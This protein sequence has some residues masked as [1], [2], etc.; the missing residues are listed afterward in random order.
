[1]EEVAFDSK[2]G[3][4]VLY[5]GS[6][7]ND[8]NWSEPTSTSEW[9]GHRWERINAPGPGNRRFH[10]LAFDESTGLT[11]AFGGVRDSA[12]VQNIVLNDVWGWDGNNWHQ[13][14]RTCPVEEPEAAFDPFGKRMLV[15]GH[16]PASGTYELW[17]FKDRRWKRIA[18]DCPDPAGPYEIAYHLKRKSL[19]IPSALGD[20]LVLWEW[21]NSK[22]TKHDGHAISPKSRNRFGFTYS[23]VEQRLYLFG[24]RS[25][26]E[27]FM[28]DLWCWDE[29]GWI[30]IEAANTPLKRAALNLESFDGKILLYGGTVETPLDKTRAGL[31]NEIWLYE[32]NAWRKSFGDWIS[33]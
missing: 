9:D 8:G 22:W 15:Y 32:L 26:Q 2:R 10:G 7:L 13:L 28:N 33:L 16:L 1:M 30:E 23:K 14:S 4:L 18:T 11:I 20:Q 17:E 24:G 12:D 5:G 19:F 3:K 27:P 21:R 31:S 6:E 25:D 29:R